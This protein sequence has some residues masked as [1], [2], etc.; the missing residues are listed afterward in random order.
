MGATSRPPCDPSGRRISSSSL[1]PRPSSRPA[2]AASPPSTVM[3]PAKRSCAPSV[4]SAPECSWSRSPTPR[5]LAAWCGWGAV[6]TPAFT[7]SRAPVRVT[8][9]PELGRLGADVVIPEEFETS[10]EI[11]ARVLAHYNV[12]RSDIERLVDQ[13]RSSHYEALRGG[14]GAGRLSLGDVAGI[15][16]MAVERLRLP[17]DSPL[18]GKTL[19]ATGLRTQTGALVLAVA[20]GADEIATPGP[21][22]RLAADDVLVV[23]GQPPQLR[24]A[25]RLVTGDHVAPT[26][27]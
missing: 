12:P 8:E 24:E 2:R 18:V 15:P 20:R 23:V 27:P 11:F 4:R 17:P 16:Q 9:I 5:R 6:S 25:A 10:I 3:P 22:F 7:S 19:A 26:P 14:D 1:T 21:H 13:I